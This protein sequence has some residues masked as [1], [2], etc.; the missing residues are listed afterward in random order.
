MGVFKNGVGR[1]SNETIKKR[2]I[3]KGVC[4]IL[5]LIVIALVAYI[6]ND[7]MKSNTNNNKIN[8]TNT[9]ETLDVSNYEQV[10][11]LFNRMNSF[12]NHLSLLTSDNN[13]SIGYDYFYGSKSI[14]N[15][16]VADDVK[17]AIAYSELYRKKLNE[18]IIPSNN[19]NTFD[20]FKFYLDDINEKVNEIFGNNIDVNN[21]INKDKIVNVNID[22]TGFK[23]DEKTKSFSLLGSGVG[24]C[25]SIEYKTKIISAKKYS[26]KIEIINKVMFIFGSGCE[27]EEE[28]F[29]LK[30]PYSYENYKN[31]IVEDLS[32]TKKDYEN[33]NIDDYLD[34]LDSYKWTFTKDKN[35][36]YIFNNVEKVK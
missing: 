21:I 31:F 15:K 2:N 18:E 33:I 1:P 20:N 30:S 35:N 36:N 4:F 14:S 26:D 25:C 5:L 32:K 10:E 12:T 17:F 23:Y 29:I 8:K 27:D 11:K 34:S 16:D 13:S 19:D 22:G 6:V 24:D 28:L 9:V 7:I 3:F